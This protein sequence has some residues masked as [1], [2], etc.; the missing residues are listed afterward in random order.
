MTNEPVIIKGTK[1]G[2]TIVLEENSNFEDVKKI[3]YEKLQSSR[4]FFA[5]AKV[6]LKTKNGYLN[7]EEH[8]KLQ[9]ILLNFGM[10]LQE[11][12]SPKTLIFPKPNR[13]RVLLLKRTVRSGQKIAYRGT[14]VILG[15]ANPGS[16]IVAT[17]D[18]LVMG[19]IRGMA[20]AGAEGD[21]SAIVAAFRLKPTQ[22]RIA[23]V[24]SRSPED[25]DESP[26]FPEVARLK[27]NIIVIEPYNALK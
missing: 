18:I 10:S 27:D 8:R 6:C 21:T 9:E 12:N 24:I 17:G 3:I 22:L 7:K 2:I 4:N 23:D 20:H 25:K 11:A 26:S 15:D 16:E 13:S 5:G 19:A 14:V 1:E